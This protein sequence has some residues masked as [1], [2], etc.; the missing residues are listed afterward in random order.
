MLVSERLIHFPDCSFS[1]CARQ[2]RGEKVSEYPSMRP[3]HRVAP[4]LNQCGH[5]H[6]RQ[7]EG[8]STQWTGT[9]TVRLHSYRRAGLQR[10]SVAAD[11]SDRDIRV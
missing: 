4:S 3:C 5:S 11:K 1:E 2:S 6:K 9:P 10:Q 8:Y 7:Y